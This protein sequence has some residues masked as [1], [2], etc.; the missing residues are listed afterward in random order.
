MALYKKSVKILKKSVKILGIETIVWDSLRL[1]SI[2]ADLNKGLNSDM[3]LFL[4]FQR[5]GFARE[6]FKIGRIPTKIEEKRLVKQ[7]E[8]V[9]GYSKEQ[10]EWCFNAWNKYISR[11]LAIINKNQP[12]V[13]LFEINENRIPKGEEIIISWKISNSVSSE[14]IINLKPQKINNIGTIRCKI[15]KDSVIVLRAVSEEKKRISKT[16]RVIV[17]NPIFIDFKPINRNIISG[18]STKLKWNVKNAVQVEVY[19][20]LKMESPLNSEKKDSGELEFFLE[21]DAVFVLI[22]RNQFEEKKA[23]AKIRVFNPPNLFEENNIQL[24]PISN[25][26]NF[27]P[28]TK[29]V[30]DKKEHKSYFFMELDYSKSINPISSRFLEQYKSNIKSL[31]IFLDKMNKYG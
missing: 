26:L 8:K 28:S 22:A 30:F 14:L 12:I 6:L 11:E 29:N 17:I 3:Q 5:I 16:K 23:Y 24:N 13:Q 2:L 9:S 25:S 20:S 7:F 27:I 19:N 21:K 1:K 10:S 4:Q 18:F 15:T 31:T